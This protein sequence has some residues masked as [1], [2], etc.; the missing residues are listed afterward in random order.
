MRLTY[1]TVPLFALM[2]AGCGDDDPDPVLPVG[3]EV[4]A[5]E[6]YGAPTDPADQPMAPM[7]DTPA[8]TQDPIA[9]TNDPMPPAEEPMTPADDDLGRSLDNDPGLGTEPGGSPNERVDPGVDEDTSA[10]PRGDGL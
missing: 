4:P 6:A 9:P 2:L 5:E 8:P 7:D 1:L 3:S 10:A